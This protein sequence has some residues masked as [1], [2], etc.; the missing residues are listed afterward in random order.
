MADGSADSVVGNRWAGSVVC[1][2]DA[3]ADGPG[4]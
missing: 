3:E 1:C 2:A 4:R